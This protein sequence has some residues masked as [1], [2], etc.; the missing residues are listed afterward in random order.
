M[1]ASRFKGI[2]DNLAPEDDMPLRRV[3]GVF[4]AMPGFVCDEIANVAG[5]PDNKRRLMVPKK[6]WVAMMLLDWTITSRQYMHR[7]A[8]LDVAAFKDEMER[9]TAALVAENSL[10]ATF[11]HVRWRDNIVRETNQFLACTKDPRSLNLPLFNIWLWMMANGEHNRNHNAISRG[12]EMRHAGRSTLEELAKELESLW[13]NNF[14]KVLLWPEGQPW[15]GLLADWTGQEPSNWWQGLKG[16]NFHDYPQL[17]GLIQ[18]MYTD[19]IA[20]SMEMPSSNEQHANRAKSKRK[21]GTKG[22]RRSPKEKLD[23]MGSPLIG[24]RPL[25]SMEALGDSPGDA[26]SQRA[27]TRSISKN[28]RVLAPPSSSTVVST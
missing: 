28:G 17:R 4:P 24:E 15:P 2:W 10:L 3:G 8:L 9:K 6:Y 18:G 5:E 13:A 19:L 25:R 14:P 23:E 27:Q 1:A 21:A 11:Y 7:R 16:S 22:K 26:A 20:R 12:R